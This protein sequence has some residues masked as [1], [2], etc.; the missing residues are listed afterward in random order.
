MEKKFLAKK[1]YSQSI[2]PPIRRGKDCWVCVC[3][4]VNEISQNLQSLSTINK[5]LPQCFCLYKLWLT[6]Q[7]I[8]S[9]D[10][11]ES[12]EIKQSILTNQF[13]PI[14]ASNFTRDFFWFP[15][16]HQ[17]SIFSTHAKSVFYSNKCKV[18]HL[19]CSIRTC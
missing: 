6:S 1:Y 11:S 12:I 5:V 13:Y 15:I 10:M 3:K 8:E 4:Y 7:T 2:L 19:R 18:W 16:F 9:V 14:K 17:N